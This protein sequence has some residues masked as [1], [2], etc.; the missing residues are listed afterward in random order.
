MTFTHVA[1]EPGCTLEYLQNVAC[2][3]LFGG[4]WRQEENHIIGVQEVRDARC[5]IPPHKAG[6]ASE[7]SR[8]GHSSPG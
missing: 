1:R 8:R 5:V 7:T 6:Q 3:L 2:H 4:H